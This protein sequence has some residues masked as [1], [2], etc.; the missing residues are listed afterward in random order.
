[1]INKILWKVVVI[2]V[3]SSKATPFAFIWANIAQQILPFPYYPLSILIITITSLSIFSNPSKLNGKQRL[4]FVNISC[5]KKIPQ[6]SERFLLLHETAETFLAMLRFR[7][8][9]ESGNTSMSVLRNIPP[10][11]LT[12]KESP[13]RSSRP[14]PASVSVTFHYSFTLAR[15]TEH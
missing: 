12:R 13:S 6:I 3:Q 1:M 11:T 8:C 14:I 4:L 7:C 10:Y 9:S 2:V 15:K 5:Q